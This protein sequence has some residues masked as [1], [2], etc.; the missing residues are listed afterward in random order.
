MRGGMVYLPSLIRR[1]LGLVRS[2]SPGHNSSEPIREELFTVERLESHARSLAVAQTVTRKPTKGYPVA[3]PLAE[4]AA[5]LLQAYRKIAQ[6]TDDGR[7]ITPTAQCLVDNYNFIEKQIREIRSDLSSGNYTQLPELAHGPFAGYPRVFGLA[8][9]FI[10]HTDSRFA[11]DLLFRYVRAYQEVEPLTIAELGAVAIT[12]RMVLVENLRRLVA[13]GTT[14]D[15]TVRGDGVA[16]ISVRNIITS[17]RVISDTDWTRWYEDGF[18]GR[19]P[20]PVA[21]VPSSFS[22]EWT[23]AG[24]LAVAAGP[25]NV[26]VFPYSTS[27][28]DHARGLET[29]RNLAAR[30][31]D[32]LHTRRVNVRREYGNALARYRDDLPPRPGEGNF[33]LADAQAR[34]LRGMFAADADTLSAPMASQLKVLLEHHIGLRNFYPEV[35]EFYGAV[36][37]GR[38]EQPLPQDAVDGFERTVRKHTP[39]VFERDVSLS[40]QEVE[41]QQ[42]AIELPAKDVRAREPGTIL[43]PPDPL[44]E[45]E[46][47]KSRSFGIASSINSLYGAFLK[48]KDSPRAVEGWSELAHSLGEYAGPIMEWLKNFLPPG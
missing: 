1:A 35:E 2:R 6:S 37:N 43:P 4:N 34:I 10:A 13:Q 26:P 17:M 25:Q 16:S 36:R 21:N 15:A 11:P 44:G 30:L 48:G 32:D 18:A 12:L 45:L 9:A 22:Y 33:M 42:P 46:P 7:A 5:A 20:K 24:R 23:S 38:L 29:S 31:F 28:M 41:R 19:P 8:W 40:L 47:R 3:R 27:E 14:A 39:D